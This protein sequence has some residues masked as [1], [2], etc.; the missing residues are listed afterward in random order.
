MAAGNRSFWDKRRRTP[1]RPVDLYAVVRY[2]SVIQPARVRD[3]SA[4]GLMLEGVG[5]LRQGTRCKVE[6]VSG[7]AF[8]GDVAWSRDH[9]VGLRF[10]ADI[11]MD[12]PLLVTS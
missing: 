6:L 10:K 12:D 1:R 9:Q 5:G 3:V 11:G 4:G 2:G 8:E 7:R